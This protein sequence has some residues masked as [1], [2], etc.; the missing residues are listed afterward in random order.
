MSAVS[1][2][3]GLSAQLGIFEMLV[4]R[5]G[6]CDKEM[7]AIHAEPDFPGKATALVMLEGVR[8][9]HSRLYETAPLIDPAA[10]G[11]QSDLGLPGDS[12]QRAQLVQLSA[13]KLDGGLAPLVAARLISEFAARHVATLLRDQIK[14]RDEFASTRLEVPRTLGAIALVQAAVRELPAEAGK[15]TE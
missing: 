7:E 6:N 12:T 1:A 8:Y 11:P 14:M 4:R 9:I 5:L 3:E 15:E 13:M 2:M 10:A